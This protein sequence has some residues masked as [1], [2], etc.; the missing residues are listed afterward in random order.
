ML[1]DAY[2]LLLGHHRASA[3]IGARAWPVIEQGRS[4]QF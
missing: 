4:S 1:V 3:A 2:R